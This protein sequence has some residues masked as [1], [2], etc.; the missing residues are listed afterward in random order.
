MAVLTHDQQYPCVFEL[1]LLE[2][3][4]YGDDTELADRET[5]GLGEPFTSW[6]KYRMGLKIGRTALYESNKETTLVSEDIRRLIDDLRELAAGRK[7]RVG[8]DP[9][10][11]DFGLSIRHLTESDASVTISSAAEIRAE[12]PTGAAN[13]SIEPCDLFDVNVWIDHPNQVDRFYGGYGP[14]LYF[15]V[16]ASDIARFAREL[17]SE[18][19]GLGSYFADRK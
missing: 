13:R 2:W 7:G 18:L 11:P 4:R 16:E 19:D 8:F 17:Q 5:T 14:G 1:A 3:E 6:V 12:V 15:Y 9:I 10:E